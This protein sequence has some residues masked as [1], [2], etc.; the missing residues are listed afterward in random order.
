[1]LQEKLSSYEIQTVYIERFEGGDWDNDYCDFG[2]ERTGD[3][4]GRPMHTKPLAWAKKVDGHY[5]LWRSS[6]EEEVFGV[7]NEDNE[8]VADERIHK[9]AL[10]IAKKSRQLCVEELVVIDKKT[11]LKERIER[12]E[13]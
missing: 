11:G 12:K 6:N 4:N 7:V 8:D 3:I 13:K 2:Y 10:K 5:V 1:M 9:E